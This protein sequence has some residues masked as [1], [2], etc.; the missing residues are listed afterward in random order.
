M[1]NTDELEFQQVY[2]TYQPRTL[3]YLIRLIGAEEAEDLTQ[4]VFVKVNQ[5]LKTFRGNSQLST[6]LYRIATNAAIDRMRSAAYRQGAQTGSLNES[7][8]TLDHE[9][10]VD[11]EASSIEQI[12]LQKERY[13]CYAR[14]V[15]DLPANYRLI[16]MLS[17][18]EE[19]TCNEIADILG[20][21][22][23]VVKIRLHRGRTRLL[24]ELKDHCKPE[25]W[26]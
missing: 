26:L 12:L 20:L 17:E 14:F 5:N 9:V 2:D 8:E 24:K 22:Q 13:N 11:K 4:E 6:W 1:L 23:D 10:W 16:V 7:P 21:S 25:E 18:M 3:R 19:M 15:K